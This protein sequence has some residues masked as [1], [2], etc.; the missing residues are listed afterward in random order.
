MSI[1]PS[2]FLRR[3]LDDEL[4]DLVWRHSILPYLEE[5]FHGEANH[6]T[7]FALEILRHGEGNLA[8]DGDASDHAD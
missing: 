7:S 1:G 3:D 6:L 8:E 4:I 2:H 5:H